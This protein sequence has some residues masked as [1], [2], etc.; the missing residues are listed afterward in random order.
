[1]NFPKRNN[2]T[3]IL[4]ISSDLSGREVSRLDYKAC[5]AGFDFQ[6]GNSYCCNLQFRMWLLLNW[7]LLPVVL[8][9]KEH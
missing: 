1:M 7:A 9:E 3:V 2:V 4:V 6:P 5:S 8:A